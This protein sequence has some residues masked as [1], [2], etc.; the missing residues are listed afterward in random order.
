MTPSLEL[1]SFWHLQASRCS[2][3]PSRSL[4]PSVEAACSAPV[5]ATASEGISAHAGAWSCLPH[6]S[7]HARLCTVTGPHACL[8]TH[9]LLLCSWLTLS[10]HGIQFSSSSQ[11]QPA[12]PSLRNE[13]RRPEHNSG[14][15]TTGQ[16][17]FWLEGQQPKHPVTILPKYMYRLN[18]IPIKLPIKFFKELEKKLF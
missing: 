10:R 4:V 8:L 16:R 13:S 9:P 2:R 12:R 14:K 18:A 5:S 15:G 6:C 3:L 11:A 7:Q 1:C 17:G